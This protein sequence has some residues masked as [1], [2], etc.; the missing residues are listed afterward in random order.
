VSPWSARDPRLERAD[1]LDWCD[2][3][4]QCP[5]CRESLARC[6]CPDDDT[7]TDPDTMETT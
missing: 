7:D 6:E 2:E 3:H 1:F 5:D 4:N